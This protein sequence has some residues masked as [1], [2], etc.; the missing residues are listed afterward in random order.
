MR[1]GGWCLLPR[2]YNDTGV[3]AEL[4]GG[5]QELRRRRRRQSGSDES[6]RDGRIL[7]APRVCG[8]S[9]PGR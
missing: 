9:G 7:G 8:R 5:G 2:V 3:C 6:G 4:A 1:G